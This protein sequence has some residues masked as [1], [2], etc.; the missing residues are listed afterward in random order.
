MSQANP[1]LPEAPKRRRTG[2]IVGIVI[3]AVAIIVAIVLVIV[4]LAN[5]GNAERGTSAD[6]PI[7]IGVVG[8]SDPYWEL[9]RQA[10][11]R[12]GIFIELVD[13]AQYE[14]VNPAL[15]DGEI[16]LN[17]FQHIPYLVEYNAGNDKD[18]RPIG[19]T[20]IYPLALYSKQY[21]SVDEIPAG[22]TIVVSNSPSNQARALLILQEEGLITL[23]DGGTPFSRLADIEDDAKVEV[24][25]QNPE[26]TPNSLEDAAAAFINN[27]FVDDA[28]LEFS[29][30]IA[31]DDPSLETAAAYVNIFA[32]RPEDV[33]NPTYLR[34]VELYQTDQAV[35][36]S[37]QEVSGGTAEF[38]QW[39]VDR[40]NELLERTTEQY[41][42]A[43]GN[44]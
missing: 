18:L 33:S 7:R 24:I 27:D 11:E 42:A 16:E 41:E 30:A 35:L 20:A 4:N 23:R 15:D 28:G 25:E 40:L 10:A 21:S 8:S 17:Q 9:Y 22:S 19:S 1:S 32:S 14:Q 3:A 44:A 5:P 39:D 13:F 26:L 31:K 37:A 12:E 6:N 29:D 43:E 2:L 34:L 36:D 38:V